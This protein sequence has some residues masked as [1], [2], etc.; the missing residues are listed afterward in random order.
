[1][2][3]QII[4]AYPRHL[5][6]AAPL[7]DQYRQ[8]YAQSPDPDGARQFVS[9]RLERGDSY[10]FLAVEGSGSR[11]TSLGFL[12][13]YPIFSSTRMKPA[14]LLNDLF[15]APESRRNGVA[16]ALMERAR[17]LALES[18]ACELILSTAVDNLNAQALY[19]SLGY[20]RETEFYQYV[21]E[22]KR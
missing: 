1:M 17:L 5:S 19:E 8:F 12:Q 9:A 10:I 16:K 6:L 21:L 15:V 7:F 14:W 3:V 20:K 13:L 2:D 11:E 18:R 22:V 4:R